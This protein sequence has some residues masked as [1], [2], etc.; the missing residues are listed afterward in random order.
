MLTTNVDDETEVTQHSPYYNYHS[1]NNIFQ[2]KV[3]QFNILSI[4]YQSICANIY[5]I[6][7]ILQR[8]RN[9]GFEFNAICLQEIGLSNNSDT[10]FFYG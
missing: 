6:S 8:L 10:Y 7:I 1:L 3:N 2:N 4:H 5:Y 9:N